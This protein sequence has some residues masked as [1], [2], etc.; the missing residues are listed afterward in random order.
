[1]SQY[2]ITPPRAKFEL[3]AYGEVYD[4]SLKSIENWKQLE[5]T[6][7]RDR[8]S[9]IF[10]QISF[11]FEFAL[12]AYDVV[13]NIYETYRHRSQGDMYI[14][15]LKNDWPWVEEQ[16]HE[17]QIF[18]LDFISYS[19]TDNIIK[20]DTKRVSLYDYLKVKNKMVYDIPVSEL[21]AEKTWNFE[22][23][24]M[25]NTISLRAANSQ[26]LNLTNGIQSK[27]VGISYESSEVAVKDIVYE[28][29]IA[30]LADFNSDSYFLE[31]NDKLE[32]PVEITF[33]INLS[34]IYVKGSSVRRARLILSTNY[35][36]SNPWS[37]S[38][39]HK[40]ITP[41]VRTSWV[42]TEK[43]MAYRGNRFYLILAL[44]TDL[45]PLK[46]LLEVNGLV[47]VEYNAKYKPVSVDM[48]DP[49]VLLQSMVDRMTNS[50]GIYTSDIEDFNTD[51]N[52]LIMLSAAESIRGIP[53]TANN[54]AKVHT[55]YRDF[56][57]WMNAYGYEQHVDGTH[58][59]IRKRHKGFRADLTAM[60]LGEREC[61][62]LREYVDEERLYPGLKIGY[63]RKEIDNV[64]GR[65]EFNGIHDYVTDLNIIDK[66]L[67]LISPY[68]ADCYGIEFLTQE[69]GKDST[70]NKSDKDLFLVN[71]KEAASTYETVT[72]VFSGNY[73]GSSTIF[74]GN[75]NPYNLMKINEDLLGVSAARMEFTASDSNAQIIID[76]QRIDQNYDIPEGAGLFDPTIYDIASRN[77]QH[78]PSGENVNG[79][80]RF[81]YK[82]QVY[83]G[84]IEEISKNPAWEM[85]TTWRL[86]KKK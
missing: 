49:K 38:G 73:P 23:I 24:M 22:R 71:V 63:N 85:E 18:N 68:R 60:E 61:A 3:H 78:L 34:D 12:E 76:G 81:R 43:F 30:S 8:T 21:K 66:V 75:L 65:F 72:S 74:N 2:S 54:E 67:E 52:N 35:D 62:D 16:Y 14:Y 69:R 36:T 33:N 39:P 70:D 82:G 37:V 45:V 4:F 1:M 7:K 51:S 53:V 19:K 56:V 42:A 80:V 84:F 46:H 40:D 9:G 79:I 25:A 5:F 59:N 41:N 15:L 77:I 20:V 57:T 47:G 17:P 27:T 44:D 83:E 50:T 55:S 11:P 26:E 32:N 48:I 13:K 29:T 6:L 10:H 86:Y 58:L 28:R 31:V 64:N